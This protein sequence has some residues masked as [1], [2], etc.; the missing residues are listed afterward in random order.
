METASKTSTLAACLQVFRLSL[1]RQ[2]FTR[3]TIVMLVLLGLAVLITYLWS[4]PWRSG[5]RTAAELAL[6][7]VLPLY[8]GFLLPVICLGYASA[9][10]ADERTGETLV[11]LLTT[12]IPR[13]LIYLSKYAAALLLTLGMTLGGLA[14]LCLVPG[15]IGLEALGIFWTVTACATAAYVGLFL[16][17]SAWVRR[18]TFLALA[19]ALMIETLTGNIP[20]VVKRITVSFYAK[21]WLY[22]SGETLGLAPEGVKLS[23][24]DPVSAATAQWVLGL[25]SVGF[26]ALGMWVFSRKE[27]D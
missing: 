7:I 5:S 21:S 11:Y 18:A 27:Y 15:K 19:Y 9:A 13:P 10:I 24:F 2:F 14:A 12:N 23:L 26:V 6:Q 20:G 4:L 16:L 17:F 3:Q 8:M 22:E 25:A 1:R